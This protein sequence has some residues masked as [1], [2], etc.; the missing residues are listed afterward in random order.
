MSSGKRKS[1]TYYIIPCVLLF[2]S[3]PMY[4]SCVAVQALIDLDSDSEDL[5]GLLINKLDTIIDPKLNDSQNAT[6]ELAHA[7]LKIAP[8]ISING[9]ISDEIKDF[10]LK[11]SCN[12]QATSTTMPETALSPS[13]SS[14]NTDE[15]EEKG[16]VQW[17]SDGGILKPIVSCLDPFVH[18]CIMLILN[19]IVTNLVTNIM[20]ETALLSNVNL[21]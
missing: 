11:F 6:R 12:V 9:T 15:N 17:K 19:G 16:D 1:I 10:R 21:M 13:G 14:K 2:L 20:T 18:F 4:I 8:V 7:L 5:I 3:H